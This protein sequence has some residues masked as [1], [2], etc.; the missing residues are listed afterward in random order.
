MKCHSK[1]FSYMT[2]IQSALRSE[3][4]RNKNR[5]KNKEKTRKWER[6]LR[7]RER[8]R[9]TKTKAV[10]DSQITIKTTSDKIHDVRYTQTQTNIHIHSICPIITTNVSVT[11]HA[12][13][14]FLSLSLSLSLS[15]NFCLFDSSILLSCSKLFIET[16]VQH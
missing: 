3:K 2:A 12:L 1:P 5:K 14:P 6:K 16:T 8:E 15:H 13:S 7:K 9:K 11:F 4:K 10:I